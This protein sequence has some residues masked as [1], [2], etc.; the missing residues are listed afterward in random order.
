M[1]EENEEGQLEKRR[2][3]IIAPAYY[4]RKDVQDAMYA[5][6]Q[7]RETVPRYLEG[8]GKR[9][10]VFDYPSDIIALA[11]KGATSF[12][13]S[14]ELWGNPLDISTDMSPEQYNKI[15]I[16]WDFLID[17]DSKYLD[18]SKI[19]AKVLIQVLEYHGVKN[20]GIKYSGSKGFHILVPYGA[21]PKELYGEKTKDK[22]PEWPRAIAGYLKEMT[23]EKINQAIIGMT[24]REKLKQKGELI[25]EHSCPNCHQS[26]IEKEVSKYKCGNCKSEMTSMKAS[27]KILRCPN[28][29]Y[30]MDKIGSSKINFCEKCKINTAQVS[31]SRSS[32]GGREVENAK[33]FEVSETTKSQVD[34]VDIVLVSP[35]HLFRAP[36]S[37]HEKTA[38]ASV[39]LTKEEMENFEVS[40]A[41]PLKM[42]MRD[43]APKPK[44]DEARELLIQSLDWAKKKGNVVTKKYEGK[45]IDVKGLKITEDIFP[46]VIKKIM[47]GMKQDGRKRALSVLL[48][49]FSSLELPQDF[50]EEKI[51]EWNGKNYKPLRDGYIKSQV[52][53]AMRNKRLPPNYDKPT[54]KELGVLSET[55]GLKN[56]INYTIREAMRRGFSQNKKDEDKNKN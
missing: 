33:R 35:R 9:P 34:S 17:I 6:C 39:V 5:F 16:G 2:V 52:D 7:H 20:I 55:Y 12:H 53:W 44:E 48:S 25:S 42:K 43:Y 3:Q 18:Y 21:F 28:C 10:D 41:D 40:L 27:R 36:Y 24:G 32:F 19:A 30:N 14:E 4:S 11:K 46:D 8:F 50:I 56:P 54:Y 51:Q 31:A 13:C 29:Q 49:F 26:T 23:G 47:Q 15:K 37:L 1:T 45:G 22:F 38:L